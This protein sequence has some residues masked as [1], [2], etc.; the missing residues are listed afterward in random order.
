MIRI[1][2]WAGHLTDM[3][4]LLTNLT[5]I[6]SGFDQLNVLDPVCENDYDYHVLNFKLMHQLF[7]SEKKNDATDYYPIVKV[8]LELQFRFTW[9]KIGK[10]ILVVCSKSG[11]VF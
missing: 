8:P 1:R 11:L 6:E 7:F 4:S 10:L 3:Y 2:F 9:K 5:R